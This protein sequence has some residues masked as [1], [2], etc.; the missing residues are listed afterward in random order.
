MAADAAE[1]VPL[2]LVQRLA[3]SGARAVLPF[4]LDGEQLLAVAQLAADNPGEPPYL[5]GG[6]SEIGLPIYR[7]REGRFQPWR[8]LP[9]SGGEDVECFAIGTRRFLATAS[10]RSGARAPYRY[11]VEST[12]YEWRD[13]DFVP[14]QR[15]PTYAAKQWRHFTV[16]A[17]HF[18]AL[19]QGVVVEGA[20]PSREYPSTIYEWDGATFV[21][22]TTVPSAWGYNWAH[23]VV[24]G[25]D[26]LAYADHA[27]PSL[28]LRWDG[29]AFTPLQPVAGDSGRAFAFFTVD[30]VAYLVFASLQGDTRLHRWQDG[31]FVAVQTAS[32]PGGRELTTFLSGGQR[33]VVQANFL[34]GS[35]KSPTT[36]L[37]SI[38]YRC[39]GGQLV[40]AAT[41]P[42]C[43]AT[44]VA[45]FVVG[46]QR[47]LVVAES[48]SAE[49]RFATDS[50][51]YAFG[52][53]SDEE[54]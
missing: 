11:E 51:V 49:V 54:T 26:H 27:T 14:F 12:I 13:G 10:L 41:F 39:E 36:A 42:T 5:N 2:V 43:G 16:G 9:V 15:V 8:T 21:P 33:Y 1:R 45:S 31:R 50:R 44:D 23:F 34:T 3:T 46:G 7:W 38:V 52:P 20:P 19:A 48:L 6:N 24:A 18:L 25:L 47:Y 35:P 37:D 30:D 22:F 28:I 40:T 32:G 29:G 53:R 4:V 17:R